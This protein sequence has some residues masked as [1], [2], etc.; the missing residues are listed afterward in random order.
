MIKLNRMTDYGAVVLSL[1]AFQYR[2]SHNAPLSVNEIA[3][4]TGLTAASISK[5]LKTL[6]NAALVASTRGKH[7]GYC[8]NKTP[9][10][11]SV[12]AIVEALEGPIALTACVETSI[13]PCNA[14][15]SCFLSGHWERINA[16]VDDAL[17]GMS[18]ADLINPESY[19]NDAGTASPSL[20]AS[21][22]TATELKSDFTR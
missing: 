18:L 16:V 22:F 17:R 11:I 2:F 5:I 4:K 14:K 7:G 8:L 6:T 15:Q 19:F 13:E 10:D 21:E 3:S 9:E 12:A 20:T 1:L